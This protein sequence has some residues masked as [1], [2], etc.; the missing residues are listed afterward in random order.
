[1]GWRPRESLQGLKGQSRGVTAAS[2]VTQ[3]VDPQRGSGAAVL[4][5][6]HRNYTASRSIHT[7][8][9][10]RM[11]CSR[12]DLKRSGTRRNVSTHA[13]AASALSSWFQ[14]GFCAVQIVCGDR[15]ARLTQHSCASQW[16]G[17]VAFVTW[18]WRR[19]RCWRS[20]VGGRPVGR[21]S[22]TTTQAPP[23][24]PS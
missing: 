4:H 9:S 17:S 2:A 24:R 10:V 21:N 22:G 14:S 23:P 8:T 5:S 7:G 1:M 13:T 3:L 12:R 18:S 19:G 16:Y 15:H 11:G 6:C 20:V